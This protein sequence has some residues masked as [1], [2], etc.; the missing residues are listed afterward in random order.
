MVGPK[1]VTEKQLAANRANALRAT[2]RDEFAPGNSIKALRVEQIAIAC[3]RLSP[4]QRLLRLRGGEN[5]APPMHIDVSV[6]EGP[7]HGA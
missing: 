7:P 5:V 1:R 2:L 6:T 3:W 4:L